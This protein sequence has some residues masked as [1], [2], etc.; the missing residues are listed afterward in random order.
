MNP[1][2]SLALKL[3]RQLYGLS[4][5]PRQRK[6]MRAFA[7]LRLGPGDIAIDCGANI[8]DVTLAM[9]SGGA[10]VHAFEPFPEA[11][12]VLQQRTREC[13]NVHCHQRA[14]SDRPGPAKLFLHRHRSADPLEHSSGSS[15][16]STK[17]N[18]DPTRF[19]DVDTVILADVISELG[20][21]QLLKID[22]EGF[23]ARLLNHLLDS[24]DIHAVD[25]VFCET[26]EFK[27]AGLYR[28]V[29]RL[30]ERLAAEGI[31]HVN[32]DWC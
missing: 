9:A 15:L 8:G 22:V 14:V 10:T 1:I 25:Q 32:L 4:K 13:P 20:Q 23:E 28:D 16:L 12:A 6:A 30:R 5:V 2:S 11:F 17:H 21:V 7:E 3:V 24:A 27:V 19:V 31:E 18:L 29:Q 26:H